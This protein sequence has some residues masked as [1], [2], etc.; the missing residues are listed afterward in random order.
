MDITS[1]N[2]TAKPT[3]ENRRGRT[4]PIPFRRRNRGLHGERSPF[5]VPFLPRGRIVHARSRT[6]TFRPRPAPPQGT[7]PPETDGA[8][9]PVRAHGVVP[10]QAE[11]LPVAVRREAVLLQASVG[12]VPPHP[13]E[14]PVRAEQHQEQPLELLPERH[15]DDEVDARVDGDE[16]VAGFDH[17]VE[18]VG[19]EVAHVLVEALDQ[20]DE[21]GE[22]VARE[23][24]GHHYDQHHGQADFS[25]LVSGE[26][27]PFSV[28]LAYLREAQNHARTRRLLSGGTISNVTR[29]NPKQF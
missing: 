1:D 8:P 11:T 6:V 18:R 26:A 16:Q 15:V 29:L 28:G 13:Q 24:D 27:R 23:E 22:E 21:E 19:V 20:V 2:Y 17:V 3:L 10:V 7:V 4:V 14:D 9:V 12:G 25:A 5:R